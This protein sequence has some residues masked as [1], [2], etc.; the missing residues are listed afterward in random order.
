[1]RQI[2]TQPGQPR[3]RFRHNPDS[4]R[5]H[6]WTAIGR[7]GQIA[8]AFIFLFMASCGTQESIVTEKTVRTETR[9]V[10]VPVPGHNQNWSISA[11]ALPQS[12]SDTLRLQDDRAAITVTKIDT[13]RADQPPADGPPAVQFGDY[14]IGL[15]VFPDTVYTTVTD[16]VI[17]QSTV[18]TKTKTK[19]GRFAWMVIGALVAAVIILLI[20]QRIRS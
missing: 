12:A 2:S 20:A 8:A 18:T 3:G 11:A 16:T 5:Q 4:P 1:M 6:R 14:L 15:E 7:I 10:Y 17:T 13:A 19:T 9:Q